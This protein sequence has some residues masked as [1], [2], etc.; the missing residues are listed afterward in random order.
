MGSHE[1]RKPRDR[2]N[3]VVINGTC[4]HTGKMRFS[5]RKAARRFARKEGL[6]DLNAYLC[7]ICNDYHLGHLPKMVR[8][9]DA[10]RWDMQPRSEGGA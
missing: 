9:G 8:D 6:N 10:V 7:T 4:P 2:G 3:F 5:S 1:R